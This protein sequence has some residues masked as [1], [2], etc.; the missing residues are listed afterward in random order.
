MRSVLEL[1]TRVQFGLFRSNGKHILG[2]AASTQSDIVKTVHNLVSNAKCERKGW[3][4]TSIG[5]RRCLHRM[6]QNWK[7]RPAW[8][9]AVPVVAQP[10]S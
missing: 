4:L 9:E 8:V 2:D 1:F 10:H 5:L 3:L 6:S 7:A